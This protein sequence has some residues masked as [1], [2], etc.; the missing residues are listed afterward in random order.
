MTGTVLGT[1]NER[2]TDSFLRKRFFS[3][4]VYLEPREIADEMFRRGYIS[5]AEHTDVSEIKT[6]YKRLEELLRIL[7][8]NN[9]YGV[10]INVLQFLGYSTLLKD[11]ERDEPLNSE[12]CKSFSMFER[13]I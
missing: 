3:L 10:F 8:Q 12:Q 7:Q 9:S 11:L 5:N 13:R 1:L 2:L 6:K 4:F